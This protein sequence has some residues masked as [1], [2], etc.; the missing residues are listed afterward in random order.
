VSQLEST[1]SQSGQPCDNAAAVLNSGAEEA[2]WEDA[3]ES[4][5]EL[6]ALSDVNVGEPVT[7]SLQ[8]AALKRPKIP[9]PVLPHLPT[10]R[11]DCAQQLE[12]VDF[13]ER[14]KSVACSSSLVQQLVFALMKLG[15]RHIRLQ[16][17]SSG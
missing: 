3:D 15:C 12:L 2:S 5:N 4:R 8:P 1:R 14:V 16:V 13:G 9:K 7:T 17:Y 6:D 10:N 11:A